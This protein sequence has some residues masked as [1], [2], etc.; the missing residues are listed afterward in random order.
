[1]NIIIRILARWYHKAYIGMLALTWP[2]TT[3]AKEQ[4][5]IISRLR[6][7][8]GGIFDAI[9]RINKY[10][11]LFEFH[12]LARGNLWIRWNFILAGLHAMIGNRSGSRAMYLDAI[13]ALENM[14]Q[15]YYIEGWS[16]LLYCKSSHEFY[17][18]C[19]PNEDTALG[20]HIF[21][22]QF[23]KFRRLALPHGFIPVNDTSTVDSIVAPTERY[24]H[25]ECYTVFRPN[26][27]DC[28]VMCHDKSI[29]K[30]KN[31][32][33]LHVNM[34]YGEVIMYRDNQPVPGYDH[35]WYFGWDNKLD[36]WPNLKVEPWW[37][38]FGVSEYI[39]WP[40]DDIQK[41]FPG[42]FISGGL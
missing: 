30:F 8:R 34:R 10:G 21:A 12:L 3:L 23:T 39:K 5:L 27:V 35:P 26:P 31:R 28:L 36:N 32:L 6:T 11:W 4:D 15:P 25:D 2:P 18:K 9:Y 42:Y 24:Y 19:A 16:Y 20:D 14:C 33:N 22:E 7:D 38:I 13:E 29:L 40:S 37:R 41:N 1:M 17:K